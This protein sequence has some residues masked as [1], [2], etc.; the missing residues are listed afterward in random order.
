MNL[1]FRRTFAASAASL[2]VLAAAAC[3]DETD[4]EGSPG[5]SST[6]SE[7]TDSGGS[8]PESESSESESTDSGG[9]TP[10]GSQTSSDGAFTFEFPEGYE[11]GTGQVSVPS[12]VASAYDTSGSEFPTTI[13]VTKESL[14]GHSLEEMADAV[15]GQLETQFDTTA[16]EAK[17]FPLSDI[18]GEDAIAYTTDA[19]DQGGQTLA[20][21]IVLTQHDGNAY[22]FILNTLDGQQGPA[23]EKFVELVETVAWA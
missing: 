12:A 18:D 11:D 9:S 14:K 15:V 21:A 17:D 7:S 8:S 1:T 5:G 20:S 6:T 10:A 2:I 13:V 3:S 16:T 19:Y 22:G 4:G 23:S